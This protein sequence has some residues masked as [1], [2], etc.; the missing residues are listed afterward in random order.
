L[1][2]RY[3]I[4]AVGSESDTVVW[5]AVGGGGAATVHA[6]TTSGIVSPP[7]SEVLIV[8]F[9]VPGVLDTE[10]VFPVGVPGDIAA[11]S[12]VTAYE[13]REVM[14]TPLAST[15]VNVSVLVPDWEVYVVC[16]IL[17]SPEGSITVVRALV[18]VSFFN[19]LMI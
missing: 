10:T 15:V 12:E 7:E 8:R 13:H 9:A 14:S 16:A 1:R 4:V 3:E 17:M 5:A 11:P 18:F 19:K 2:S 6:R